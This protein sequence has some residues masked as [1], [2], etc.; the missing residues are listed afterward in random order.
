MDTIKEIEY[1]ELTTCVEKCRNYIPA[2]PW[3]G[4]RICHISE[5]QCANVLTGVS[6]LC[7]S[8]SLCEK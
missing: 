5:Y 7:V 1:Q 8:A 3:R 2:P 4:V 6:H